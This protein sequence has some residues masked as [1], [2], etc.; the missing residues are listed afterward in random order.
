MSVERSLAGL[1]VWWPALNPQR[2]LIVGP[3]NSGKSTLAKELGQALKL[4]AYDL[5][6]LSW[7]PGWQMRPHQELREAVGK[8]VNTPGW[9][10][11]GNYE[12]TQD[13]SWPRA[14][15]VIWLDLEKALVLRRAFWRCWKRIALQEPCCNGNYESLRMTFASKDS[16]LRWIWTSHARVRA[17]YQQRCMATTGPLL[18][19]LQRPY[20]VQQFKQK[21][22]I[23][24]NN[25]KIS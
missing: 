1:P 9:I 21:L 3:S 4:P 5:D 15:L 10:I 20:Q 13:L 18:L 16:L 8:V 2:L 24:K 7:L 14:E 22:L 6:E 11:A 23:A 25:C 17:R 19:H 12:R